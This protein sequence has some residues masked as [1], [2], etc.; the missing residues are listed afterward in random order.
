[1]PREKVQAAR[2]VD[3]EVLGPLGEGAEVT[4]E[5]VSL[6]ARAYQIP[7]GDLHRQPVYERA[8]HKHAEYHQ[9]DRNREPAEVGE[10][11]DDGD[12]VDTNGRDYG[13]AVSEERHV[14]G[15]RGEQT[16]RA[17]CLQMSQWRGQYLPAKLQAQI[18]DGL[19]GEHGQEH[20]RG[21]TCQGVK[22]AQRDEG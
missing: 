11:A 8:G 19:L 16:R 6:L 21:G 13:D 22:G 5:L 7:G 1:M 17:D 2:G 10:T 20:F 12:G 3:F 18:D 14:F 15:E 4:E 9:Q